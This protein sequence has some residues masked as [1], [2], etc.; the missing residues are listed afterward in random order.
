MF[1]ARIAS[2]FSGGIAGAR[3]EAAISVESSVAT[4]GRQITITGTGME[5]GQAFKLTLDGASGVYELGHA[6]ATQNGGEAALVEACTLPSELTSGSY[7]L[8]FVAEGGQSATPDLT[9]AASSEQMNTQAMEASAESLVLDRPKLPLL[10]GSGLV[11]A[12]LSAG[13][14]M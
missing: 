3:G 14:G 4:P 12:R 2:L 7:L 10:I 5:D 13:L 1:I 11:L 9:I 8:L 6:N